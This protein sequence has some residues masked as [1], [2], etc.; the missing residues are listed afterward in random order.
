MSWF[1]YNMQ[2]VTRLSVEECQ[3]RLE[4]EGVSV[5]KV[6]SLLSRRETGKSGFLWYKKI[7]LLSTLLQGPALLGNLL[8]CEQGCRI[9]I[10]FRPR[11]SPRLFILSSIPAML[12]VLIQYTISDRAL[13]LSSVLLTVIL[14]LAALLHWM[15][16]LFMQPHWKQLLARLQ[17]I[18][19]VDEIV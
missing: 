6:K 7:G 17:Q 1:G 18:I 9:R 16:L 11:V 14:I 15:I 19:A 4:A 12:F 5:W 10:Y 2:F 8:P 3:S 13:L